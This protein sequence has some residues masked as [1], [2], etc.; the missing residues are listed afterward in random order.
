MLAHL[1]QNTTFLC[2][3]FKL[4]AADG[5]VAAYS[6]HTRPLS[7][8]G[9]T[10]SPAPIDVGTQVEKMNLEADSTDFAG[11][12]DELVR[13]GDI[14]AGKWRGA[15]AYTAFVCYLDLTMGA[16]G[17]KQWF[18]GKVRA[19]SGQQY[20]MELLSLSSRLQ[21]E[22]GEATSPTDRNRTLA[23]TGVNVA[24]FTH[25]AT[26]TGVTSRRVFT[27]NAAQADNYFRGGQA[28]WTSGPNSG[29][30]MEVKK[31]TGTTIELQLP[32]PSDIAN[33]HTLN[34]IRGY[35]GTRD[36]A[37]AL[38]SPAIENFNGE[39]DMPGLLAPITYPE[40]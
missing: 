15:R 38:G 23:D 8:G 31:N 9:V 1:A 22:I 2:Q 37:K 10:Y 16:V 40:G 35:T 17:E 39:P 32:M 30:K 20:Q 36:E 21:Q 13:E 12:F 25:A 7:F 4:T 29:R 19:R 24:A 26:V 33:G 28:V 11:V 14:N 34:L 5:T 6:T 27:V 18:V 3:L